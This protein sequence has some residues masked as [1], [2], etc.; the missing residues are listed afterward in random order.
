LARTGLKPKAAERLR[1]FGA[2]H[3]FSVVIGREKTFPRRDRGKGGWCN[4]A[5]KKAVRKQGY[6]NVY[7]SHDSR[8][9]QLALEAENDGDDRMF[10]SALGIPKCCQAFYDRCKDDAAKIQ[11]DFFPFSAANIGRSRPPLC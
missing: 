3:G 4:S 7:I 11:N 2:E 10:G 8:L 9:A 5:R 1:R 6:Y